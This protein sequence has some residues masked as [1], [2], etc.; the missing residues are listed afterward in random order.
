MYDFLLLASLKFLQSGEFPDLTSKLDTNLILMLASTFN[1]TE[2]E[3]LFDM[4]VE[5]AYINSYEVK[6]FVASVL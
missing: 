1:D 6:R 2:L 5:Y 4:F 3:T